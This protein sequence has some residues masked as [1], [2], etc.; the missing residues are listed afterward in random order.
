MMSKSM[1]SHLAFGLDYIIRDIPCEFSYSA[2]LR[3]SNIFCSSQHR[4]RNGNNAHSDKGSAMND[5]RDVQNER[6]NL[7]HHRLNF[8][9]VQLNRSDMFIA[10]SFS[11][12]V[13]PKRKTSASCIRNVSTICAKSIT[14]SVKSRRGDP[15][16]FE[17]FCALIRS[18]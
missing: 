10:P 5:V 1:R 3:I 6:K 16:G 8:Q 14:Q 18:A 12:H 9:I 11:I 15:Y 7:S 2:S 17:G 4:I 13:A